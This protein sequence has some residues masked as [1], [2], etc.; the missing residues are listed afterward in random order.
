MEKRVVKKKRKLGLISIGL[1]LSSF[2]WLFLFVFIIRMIKC[3]INTESCKLLK[4]G[5]LTL[6]Q[7]TGFLG[8]IL[9]SIIVM[10]YAAFYKEKKE[11]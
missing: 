9:A 2:V 11:S 3:D 1:F 7:V 8:I 5:F 6:F 10:F 4:R